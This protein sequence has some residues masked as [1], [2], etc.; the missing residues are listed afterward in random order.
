MTDFSALFQPGRIG[1]LELENR[2]LMP[3]MASQLPEA[4]GHLSE[5]LLD[6][7][8]ARAGGG[9][10]L[11]I[12]AYAAVSNDCPLMFNMALCD[13][14]WISD[15]RKLIDSIHEHGVKVGVQLMH[16][17]M[18]YLFAGFVPKGITMKVASEIPRIP[19]EIPYQVVTGDDIERY[20]EDFARAARRAKEAGADMV[21]IHSCHGSLAGMFMSPILNRRTDKYGGTLEK[22]ARFPV[23]V[24]MR[25]KQ[26]VGDDFP[27]SMRINGSDDLDGG[28]TP[29]EAAEQA[30]I[31][32]SAGADAISVSRGIEFWVGTTVPSYL[33][34][35][36]PMMPLVDEIKRAV[37]IPVMA[38]GKITPEL[39]ADIVK[40]E[41]A[42]FIAM[43]RPLLAD[44]E[45]PRKL[46]E[47][48]A[49]EVR[50][51]IYCMNCLN[52]DRRTGRGSCSVNPFLNRESQYPMEP[53][54]PPK[55]VLVIGG[56]LAGMQ[57][58]RLLAER[59]HKV[60]L[61][62]SGPELGG[63]WKVAASLPDKAHFI[64]LTDY[65]KRSLEKLGIEVNA[66]TEI[67]SQRVQQDGP[68]AVVV[69]TGASPAIPDI[70]GIKGPN[71][72]QA[73][74]VIAGK[75]HPEGKIVVLGGRYLAIETAIL[76]A[77][78]GRQV[79]LATRGELGLTVERVTLRAL[80]KKLIDLMVPLYLH[81]PI[82]EITPKSVVVRMGQETASLPADTVVLAMGMEPENHLAEELEGLVPEIY[83]VGDCVKP[84]NAASVAYQA[85]Q[86][87]AKI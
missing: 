21:E 43:G 56:G 40:E 83:S 84:R 17:G 25:I 28:T 8:R 64:S 27:V 67:T 74:D 79:S 29:A 22:R 73:V 13:D 19:P 12:P 57:T 44:P 58:A 14:R 42:E 53:A 2:L 86:V 38:A 20:I 16:V 9:V 61:Y 49:D 24:I 6:Y 55:K 39:A 37:S 87:A 45:L 72:V 33:Y 70:A 31:L 18:L 71:V 63:Q 77:E 34:P 76:M 26:V 5:R 82:L 59:G 66:N 41:R 48:R 75:A 52:Q 23:E 50:R 65:L 10:G 85:A 80:E 15:W 46:H 11:I 7:Y 1:S 30:L 47:G 3:A 51:C 62:E 4:D 78:Q 68:D 36:G 54:E 81:T 60:S 69:A 35:D 32:Q